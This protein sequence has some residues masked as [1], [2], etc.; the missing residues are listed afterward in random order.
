MS[1]FSGMEKMGLAKFE[2]ANLM[3]K[4]KDSKEFQNTERVVTTVE[5]KEEDILFD[6]KYRCP[7][8]DSVF[9]SKCVRT[10]R[11]KIVKKDTDLRPIYN[12]F[13]PL[14]YDAIACDK[15]GYAAISKYFGKVSTRQIKAISEA[16]SRDFKGINN[17]LSVYTYDDAMLRYKLAL[18]SSLVKEAKDGEKAYTCLKYAWILRGKR[19][20][21]QPEDAEYKRLYRDELECIKNAYEGF[22]NA[23]ASETFPIGGMDEHTLKFVMAECA[24]KLHKYD[25]ALKLVG[26]ILV[27]RSVSTRVKNEALSL[28]EA[29][30]SDAHTNN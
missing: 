15:C 14:K 28:K 2:N 5:L 24:R 7:V 23:L 13:D 21:L 9:T 26:T 1:I 4:K 18:V 16:V 19:L 30:I 22:T 6:K 25:D 20:C 11:I 29:I 8:C 12:H 17:S 10:G 3:E 27:S